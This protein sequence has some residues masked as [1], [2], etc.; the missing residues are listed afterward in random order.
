MIT[1][2]TN[3]LEMARKWI[4]NNLTTIYAAN[5][6]TQI[7]VTMLRHINPCC[8]DKPVLT[9]AS[10]AYAATLSKCTTYVAVTASQKTTQPPRQK[11]PMDVGLTFE[12]TDFPQLQTTKRNKTKPTKINNTTIEKTQQTAHN[13]TE[14]YDYKAELERLS[15]EIETKL[16][17]QFD[18]I[19]VKLKSKIDTLVQ[20]NEDQVKINANITKQ[21]AFLVDNMKKL[22]KHATPT[23]SNIPT[24]RGAGHS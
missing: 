20:Q 9:E 22:M 19:F 18:K 10:K 17:K 15:I 1:T 14:P 11:K 16:R 8:L 6:T 2:T 7:D 13:T 5:I 24:P 3:Q 12:P 23:T 21:L 4:D